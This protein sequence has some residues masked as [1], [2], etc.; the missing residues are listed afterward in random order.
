MDYSGPTYKKATSSEGDKW[1]IHGLR[2]DRFYAY[3]RKI[4]FTGYGR[5]LEP[6]IGG[7][8]TARE[9]PPRVLQTGVCCMPVI[10]GLD[11]HEICNPQNFVKVRL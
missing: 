4:H 3:S 7:A 11:L 1:T 2:F 9:L 5:S 6:K 8:A 10:S